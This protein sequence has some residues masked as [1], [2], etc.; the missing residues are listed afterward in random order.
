MCKCSQY[1]GRQNKSASRQ[2]QCTRI[3]GKVRC[4]G[5][6]QIVV[7]RRV[8]TWTYAYSYYLDDNEKAKMEL[9]EYLQ[10]KAEVKLERLH[11]CTEIDLQD[12]LDGKKDDFL[13]F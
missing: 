3:A 12:Y 9:F 11:K 6:E 13:Q 7:C 4:R 8:L 5:L 10:G 1:E 2:T